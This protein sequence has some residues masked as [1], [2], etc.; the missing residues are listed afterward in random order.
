MKL[1]D[2][3]FIQD[4]KV[5]ERHWGRWNTEVYEGE[6]DEKSMQEIKEADPFV[7]GGHSPRVVIPQCT[8]PDL[9]E[10]VEVCKIFKSLIQVNNTLWRACGWTGK[11]FVECKGKT[12]Q[13]AVAR[14]WIKLKER[15]SI[16]GK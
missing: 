11:V 1:K 3:G 12:P 6:I 15:R 8:A 10:L 16:E 2:H 4:I 13:E 5:I 14:L 9:Y 7:W